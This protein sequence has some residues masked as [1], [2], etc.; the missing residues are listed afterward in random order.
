M[1]LIKP[2]YKIENES[3]IN[4]ENILRH[5]E[6][7]ARTCYKSEDKAGDWEKT[8]KFVGG[9][10]KGGH[11]S[12]IEHYSISVRIIASRSF[13]HELVRHRLCAYSQEC[14]TWDTKVHK[15]Y[16]IKDLY[17]R[18]N[19]TNYDKTH[20]KTIN[21][22]SVNENG[23]IIPN[24]F[25][26]IFYKGIQDVYKLTT[27]LGYNIKCTL[28][29]EFKDEN[30]S[31]K[32]LK[33]FNLGDKLFV[34]GRSSLLKIDDETLVNHYLVEK[35]NPEEISNL[36][37]IPLSSVYYRLSKKGIF[38]K[39]LND[40]N[41]E[42]YNKNHTTE[43]YKKMKD[44]IID[45]YKNGRIVWNKGIKEAENPS[46]KSQAENL[47]KNHYNN[48]FGKENSR[49]N[50]GPKG[51]L[52]AE[53]LKKNV[54]YCE[55]CNNPDNCRLE[56]HHID[57]NINNND[58]ENLIK[59]CNHCHNLLHHGWEVG[60]KEVL[61]TIVSIE[62]VGKEET[63]DIEM[64]EPYH[65]YIAN[66]FVVHNSTRYCNYCN[67]KYGD[68]ITYI[69]PLWTSLQ[70]GI[71]DVIPNGSVA[72][73]TK[74]GE[75]F[76]GSY[77]EEMWIKAMSFSEVTYKNL[78][79]NGWKPEQARMILP[80]SLKTEIVMTCNLREMRHIFTLRTSE[81]A[82]PEMREIMRPLLHECKEKI[83]VIFD[84]L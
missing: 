26:R 31:F 10:I 37:Y 16:T 2:Y 83:P 4:G 21:L 68:H 25:N 7:A 77:E 51:N 63:Y 34:N 69:I 6:N 38:I 50:G 79:K 41:K 72:Y 19:G 11:H 44:T 54:N 70:P 47:R 64:K 5:I 40:K 20:N 74:D 84:D 46:V 9:L 71:Y 48:G 76:K 13:T 81:K 80:N 66:G 56:V 39:R 58:L 14:I 61:D 8:K 67:D 28:E 57:K 43:S 35:L 18:Q 53:I 75:Y 78:I 33:L 60:K 24:K 55:L 36:Y 15:N 42:K 73:I 49:W 27:K 32:K 22:K 29:H 12:T 62:Y 52:L 59:C 23:L 82:H 1:R 45:Q 65:N 30:S 17:M 3:E